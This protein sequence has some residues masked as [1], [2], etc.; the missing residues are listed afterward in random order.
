M[1]KMSPMWT[2]EDEHA[3]QG[4]LDPRPVLMVRFPGTVD[5]ARIDASFRDSVRMS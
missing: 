1:W 2:D 3:S 5:G 4:R